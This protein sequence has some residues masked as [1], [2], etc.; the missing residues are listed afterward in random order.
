MAAAGGLG[1]GVG[2]LIEPSTQEDRDAIATA[3]GAGAPDA[4][5]IDG[6][7]VVPGSSGL[8]A[9]AVRNGLPD[10]LTVVLALLALSALAATTPF[11]RRHVIGRFRR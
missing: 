6:R 7:A 5:R 4:V 8:T 9:G 10:L 1:G 3:A 2:E 11:F